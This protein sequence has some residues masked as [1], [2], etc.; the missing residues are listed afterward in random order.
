V[1]FF[2]NKKEL[3]MNKKI[4]LLFSGVLAILIL[5]GYGQYVQAQPGGLSDPIVTKAYVD[6]Q[7]AA[8]L[9][10]IEQN[11]GAGI[12][13]GISVA[14][15]DRDTVMAEM[16]AYFEAT[17][18]QA[19]RNAAGEGGLGQIRQVPYEAVRAPAGRTLIGLSGTEMILRGGSAV[20]VS[21]I[22]GLCNVT[23]GVDVVDGMDIMLNHLHIVPGSD[24]R[25][26]RFTQD[27][28]LMIKGE[29]YFV[30]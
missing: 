20:A 1:T 9:A 5:T 10:A 4:V 24:G 14:P 16:I 12:S 29:Y 8:L 7:I 28:F 2:I 27:S 26:M 25:G 11:G 19:L 22:N 15:A 3:T 23:L 13:T 6:E 30:E 21:G 18:G 17:Y